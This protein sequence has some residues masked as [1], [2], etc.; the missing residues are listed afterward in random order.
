MITL[1][2]IR[3]EDAEDMLD[4]MHDPESQKGFQKNILGVTLEEAREFCR[5]A[6]LR[7]N[8]E[9]GQSI[10]LAVAGAGDEYLGTIS[11]KE[12]NPEYHSAELAIALRKK[13]RGKG[14]ATKAVELLLKKAF[15]EMNL[16]RIY[17]TVLADNIPA[18][19]LYERCGFVFEG[20][21]RDHLFLNGRYIS[22]KLYGI[23]DG[24]FAERMQQREAV[25]QMIGEKQKL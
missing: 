13:A 9:Q 7:E 5:N 3:E 12:I 21:L 11:L 18:I 17:L 1:R 10:H 23:L 8:L 20:E 24:E 19:R 15:E 2:E 4:W 16:H 25:N 6:K 14:I 22:W